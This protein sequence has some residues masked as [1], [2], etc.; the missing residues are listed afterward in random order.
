MF[1]TLFHSVILAQF[2]GLAMVITSIILL[3]RAQFYRDMLKSTKPDS[4]AVCLSSY[5]GLL[6]GIFLVVVHNLWVPGFRTVVTVICWIILIRSILWLSF[7]E[8]SLELTKKVFA[9]PMFYVTYVIIFLVGIFLVARGFYHH[10][11]L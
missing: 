11:L 5:V 2:L 4:G 7:P 1:S 6:L 10:P 3:S 8:K 9:G